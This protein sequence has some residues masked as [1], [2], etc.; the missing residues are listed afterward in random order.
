MEGLINI[1]DD[2]ELI[3]LSLSKI[4]PDY[5]DSFRFYNDIKEAL[6]MMDAMK[7]VKNQLIIVDM[8]LASVDGIQKLMSMMPHHDYHIIL[9]TSLPLSF[10][11][12]QISKL[13]ITRIFTKPFNISELANLIKV[14]HRKD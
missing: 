3:W 10:I 7:D 2:C 9:L 14:L 6:K 13:D 11:E 4:L 1:I 12:K 8:E 5:R